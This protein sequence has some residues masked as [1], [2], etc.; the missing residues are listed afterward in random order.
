MDKP[1]DP[2]RRRFLLGRRV[3][4]VAR[5][6]GECLAR[7]GI[8]CMSCREACG[9]NAIRLHMA[10]GG[11]LPVL[12]PTLCTGCGDCLAPCPVSAITL[13]ERTAHA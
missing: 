4:P 5:L 13:V 12:D 7:R 8:T 1:A 9:E 11:A 2:G 3:S 6:G 10:P